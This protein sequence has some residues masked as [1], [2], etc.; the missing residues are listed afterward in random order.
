VSP[1]VTS[2]ARFCQTP[3]PLRSGDR[4]DNR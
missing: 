4:A 2:R 1:L 3:L